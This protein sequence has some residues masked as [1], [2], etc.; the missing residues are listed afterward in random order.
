MLQ[1]PEPSG[2]QCI[3]QISR[4]WSIWGLS[5]FQFGNVPPVRSIKNIPNSKTSKVCVLSETRIL[6]K[7]YTAH[8][9][10]KIALHPERMDI[11]P[12][13]IDLGELCIHLTQR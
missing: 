13:F 6:E 1:N 4:V 7:R 10:R 11:L 3:I 9:S 12:P 2:C 5:D 8:G